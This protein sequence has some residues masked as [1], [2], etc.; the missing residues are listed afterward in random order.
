M[1]FSVSG[2]ALRRLKINS[3]F[4]HQ[5]VGFQLIYKIK[6]ILTLPQIQYDATTLRRRFFAERFAPRST[7]RQWSQPNIANVIFSVWTRTSTGSVVLETSP[8]V[9]ATCVSPLMLVLI[10]HRAKHTVCSRQIGL[11]NS[12]HKHFLMDAIPDKVG[13]GNDLQPVFFGK[14]LKLRHPRHRAVVIHYLADN[15]RRLQARNPRDINAR[16]GLPDAHQHTAVLRPQAEKHA[17]AAQDPTALMSDQRRLI[18]FWPDQ[19]PKC[20]SSRPREPRSKS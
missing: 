16:L 10:K 11:D 2:L 7:L 8:I 15:R 14:D 6:V 17:P 3:L 12:P 20:P 13:D 19:P 5:S 9:N 18:S 4:L 1:D